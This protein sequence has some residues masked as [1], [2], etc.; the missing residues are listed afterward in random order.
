ML[1][2]AV[3]AYRAALQVYTREALPQDWAMTQNNLA[4]TL[5]DQASASKGAKKVELLKEAIA[6]YEA[7]LRVW[8]KESFPGYHQDAQRGL[9]LAQ[10]ALAEAEG[11]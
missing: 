10:A 9:A 4:A 2:E 3:K 1:A 8:T 11:K 6:C 7:A 5:S